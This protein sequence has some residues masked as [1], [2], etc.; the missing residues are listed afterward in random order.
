MIDIE[1]TVFICQ[2][3]NEFK[4]IQDYLLSSEYR[5]NGYVDIGDKEDV[6]FYPSAVKHNKWSKVYITVQIHHGYITW[7][8][9]ISIDTL[10]KLYN[11]DKPPDWLNISNVYKGYGNYLFVTKIMRNFKLKEILQNEI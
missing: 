8:N 7:D 11:G 6:H 4:W 10:M 9:E 1:K 2:S 5:W 3:M